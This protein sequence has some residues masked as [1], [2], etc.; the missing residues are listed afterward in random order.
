[1]KVIHDPSN[2]PTI[3]KRKAAIVYNEKVNADKSFKV[4]LFF[5]VLTS[6]G[7]PP[8]KK[9]QLPTSR[10]IVISSILLLSPHYS[11][12]IPLTFEIVC[13]NRIKSKVTYRNHRMLS[14]AVSFNGLSGY[15]LHPRI[16]TT[17]FNMKES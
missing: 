15:S 8:K 1:M 2:T 6:C 13:H 7:N 10:S 11:L 4:F 16:V 14:L 12:I 17:S 9:R 3:T 5:I